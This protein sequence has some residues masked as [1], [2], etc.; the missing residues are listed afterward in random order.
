MSKSIAVGGLS[1]FSPSQV[2]TGA[3]VDWSQ[4]NI[5]SYDTSVTLGVIAVDNAFTTNGITNYFNDSVYA[6]AKQADGKYLIAGAF[7]N[8]KGTGK[9]RL[10]RLNADGTEDTA[11]TANAI[12]SGTTPKFNDIVWDVKVQTDGKIILAGNFTAYGGVSNKNSVI[13]LNA[14]GTEDTTFTANA[15]LISGQPKFNNGARAILIQP[16]GKILIGGNW[17]SYG[18]VSN[19][20]RLIRLNS[21]GTEDTA[22]TTNAVINGGAARFNSSIFTLDLDSSNNIYVGGAFSNYSSQTGKNYF[23]KLLPSGIEDTVFNANATVTGTTPN[24]SISFRYI[25]KVKVLSSGKIMVGGEFSN[26]KAQTGKNNLILLN[27]NGT[28]DTSFSSNAIVSGTVAKIN[29]AVLS[30]GERDGGKIVV[31]GEFT[32]YNGTS[33]FAFGLNSDGTEDIAFNTAVTYSGFS[34]L[35]RGVYA[36]SNTVLFGGDFTNY[37]AVGVN[38]LA[39]VNT[40]GGV[41]DFTNAK[42]GQTITIKIVNSGLVDYTPVWPAGVTISDS[43]IEPS[44]TRIYNFIKVN[45][46]IYGNYLD[47]GV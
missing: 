38:K 19:K 30:I 14:D 24:F 5:F 15:V 36:D 33:N 20:S 26:Y 47:I 17:T 23:I 42:E 9:S 6:I 32:G 39:K 8:Y 21:D 25:R 41:F 27:S 44:S 18:L 7:T 2:L 29:G 3:T 34:S 31:T 22:F 10:I 16:D 12:V 13:R 46:I 11:F 4:A 1:Q 37:K 43:A 35:V 28:E 40:S 45:G